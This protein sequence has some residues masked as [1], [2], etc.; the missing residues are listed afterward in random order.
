LTAAEEAPGGASPRPA[1][2][3]PA[4]P[5]RSAVSPI[6]TGGGGF[7]LEHRVGAQYLALLLTGWG[8]GELGAGR[9]IT[10]ISF[11][12]APRVPVDDLVIVAELPD[13]VDSGLELAVGIRRTPRIVTSDADTQK[14]IVEYVRA[15]LT[16]TV[17][18]RE[19]RLALVV[20]GHGTHAEQ[21]AELADLAANQ[22][23]AE[24]YFDLVR[25][26]KYNGALVD[27][28]DHV[29]KL[30]R[31]ALGELGYPDASDVEVGERT[32]ELL[33]SLTVLMPEVEEPDVSDRA[34]TINRLTTVARGGDLIAATALIDRLEVLAARF[35]SRAATVDLR[36]L[37]RGVHD[38]IE[39]GQWR[40]RRAWEALEH[41]H[42]QALRAVRST[43]GT[44]RPECALHLDRSAHSAQVIAASESSPAVLVTGE[45]GTGKSAIG[46]AAAEGS[47]DEETQVLCIN[48]RHLPE[49]SVELVGILG[50]TL[51]V[52]LA[53]L[54]APR[55]LLVVDGAD[56][57]VETRGDLFTYLVTA[58]HD[59]EVRV[60]AIS[61]NE[62]A[63]VI[64]ALMAQA[65]GTEVV[66]HEVVGLTDAELAEVVACYPRLAR[67]ADSPRSRE[68]L[69]R[70]VVVDLLVRGDVSGLPLSDADAMVEIWTSLVRHN[71]RLDRGS[72]TARE[73]VLI[74]LARRELTGGSAPDVAA[75]L[76]PDAV[77]WLLQDGLL[78]AASEAPWQLLPDFSHDEIRRY[79]VA[80]VLL[81]T[82]DV[83]GALLAAGAPR[84]ALGAARLACQAILNEPD[85]PA[86]PVHGRLGRIQASFETLVAAGH[87]ER[88]A[89]VPGEALLT[90][91]DPGPVLRDAWTELR[92]GEADG[93]RRLLRLI[94]QRHRAGGVVDPLVVEPIVDLLLAEETP[95]RAGKEIAAV[96]RDWL[97]ALVLRGRPAGHS[98]R[99]RLRERLMAACSAGERRMIEAMAAAGAAR[100]AKGDGDVSELERQSAMLQALGYGHRRRRQRPAVPSELTDDV[101]LELLALLGPDLGDAAEKLLRRVAADTPW[102]LAPAV[103]EIFS[104]MALA[105]Y[106][107]GLLADLVEAYYLDEE[108]D[109]S[110]FHGDG[111]RDHH[112]RLPVWPLAVYYRGPFMWLF[113]T[114][115]ARGVAVLNRILNHAARARVRRVVG[116]GGPFAPPSPEDLDAY[117]VELSLIGEPRIYVGDE[118]VWCWY[119]GTAVGPPPCMSA[120]QALER[121]CDELVAAGVPLTRIVNVLL[122]GCN[123]LAMVGILV[124]H[125]EAGGDLLDPFLAEP[126]V[127]HFDIRR[128]VGEMSGLK[129]SS[130]GMT[131]ADRREWTPQEVAMMLVL[132]ADPERAEQ[133]RAVGAE[134]VAKAMAMEPELSQQ[135]GVDQDARGVSFTTTV[136]N[137][138]STLDRNQYTATPEG[139][140]IRIEVAPPEDVQAALEPGNADLRRGQ[141]TTRLMLRYFLDRRGRSEAEPLTA[142]ELVADVAVAEDLLENP[143]VS[144]VIGVWDAAVAVASAALEEHLLHGLD[145][146][147]GVVDF[148]VAVVV[149][150]GEGVVTAPSP[151]ESEADRIVAK[152][153]PLLLLPLAGEL[154]VAVDDDIAGVRD[155]VRAAVRSL[156]AA[157]PNE[158]RLHLAWALDALWAESCVP[159]ECHHELAFGMIPELLADCVLGPWDQET[160]RRQHL[161]L[162]EPLAQSIA[163]TSDDDID[164]SRLDAPIRA[165]GAA[166]THECCVR[167]P[168]RHL[169]DA[170]VAA[171][172]RV[173]LVHDY[174]HRNS[175][176]MVVA[177]ALLGLAAAGDEAPIHQHIGMVIDNGR[178]LSAFLR[179]LAA[180]AEENPSAAEAARRIW[181][182]V[183]IQ[184]L[185]LIAAGHRP[186]SGGYFGDAALAALV[187]ESTPEIAF[188]YRQLAST[189]IQ[190]LDVL[191]WRPAIERWLPVAA[192]RAQCVD[193]LVSALRTIPDSDQVVTGLPW[194]TALVQADGKG[195]AARSFLLARW[196]IEI[197]AGA[198]RLGELGTWQPLV[199]ALVVAG[200]TS[201]AP[202]SE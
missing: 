116:L 120:L 60:I 190:W 154:L 67:L 3:A 198:A 164:P 140:R 55:R 72:P 87:G 167:A 59:A 56:A 89:D 180:A 135:G 130:E 147:K 51:E 155:R 24:A 158:T 113:R 186:F 178:L 137:W 6:S 62:A 77:D 194:I 100:A 123:N 15:L 71:N 133:L 138:A 146:P 12:Q 153:L 69:R 28:L 64:R 16:P 93:L 42:R 30:V 160:Q 112:S 114:D 58:A 63:G 54:S 195:V 171:H 168:A 143:P 108:E 88:W 102:H 152:A 169:L 182:D 197:R 8:A 191:A 26:P 132:P 95:W 105:A 156:A 163:V 125:L 174:D 104:G 25:T 193:A 19:H 115:F 40:N 22:K 75:A 37:R 70:L 50:C 165:L 136:R 2:T 5:P 148:A 17:D 4:V 122:D 14:L 35:G 192:G 183:M 151:F 23:D 111:V 20:A 110:G 187:P 188:L 150:V 85:T 134:M 73:R 166:A 82:G 200:E 170:L 162:P 92:G 121:V 7:T 131:G 27:R 33:D 79:A 175:S 107:R 29:K 106:G 172:R 18:A 84:W 94:D 57:A 65:S 119:R 127:W 43:L 124:R 52:A 68:L 1:S 109:G 9:V 176:T 202:Y 48:L 32:W 149:F 159:G 128:R 81:E 41:L 129:A 90:L 157:D 11:Q 49:N 91:G 139:E 141:E 10:S 97:A 66:S 39:P 181:P 185:D 78:R 177:R 199:D 45:S 201:L 99:M 47:S 144:S 184:V 103:D 80:R 34:E 161:S 101:M 83:T 74:Q 196:L 189:P 46:L 44:N 96:L 86:N 98:L 118:H 53:E 179:A 13:G 31:H 145:L 36:L 117:N 76:D 61:S 126:A 21:L 142:E 173:L 38:L